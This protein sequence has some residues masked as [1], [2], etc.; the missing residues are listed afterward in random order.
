MVRPYPHNPDAEWGARRYER[1]VDDLRRAGKAALQRADLATLGSGI[2]LVWE[3][4]AWGGALGRP[5]E[6]LREHVQAGA[7]FVR[8]TMGPLDGRA[9]ELV[10]VWRFGTMAL[11]AGDPSLATSIARWR[12]APPATDVEWMYLL[13]GALIRGDDA[14]AQ[15]NVPQVGRLVA[16]PAAPASLVDHTAYVAEAVD[17]LLRLDHAALT[18]ALVARDQLLPRIPRGT[19]VTRDWQ[20]LL[21]RTGCA[22]ALLGVQRGLPLPTGIA[23]VPADLLPAIHVGAHAADR[24]PSRLRRF[25]AGG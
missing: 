12:V 9:P 22:I 8:T 6:E 17:A 1:A 15:E 10:D 21:D 18:G 20:V 7:D 19:P 5:A 25:L 23:T 13:V 3:T 4:V 24:K 14:L 16:A 11:L 2:D